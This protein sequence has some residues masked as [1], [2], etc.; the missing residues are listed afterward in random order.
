MLQNE[1]LQ[2]EMLQNEML[3]NEMLQKL[4]NKNS[5]LISGVFYNK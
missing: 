2:N 4:K 5:S 1:M 3:Q